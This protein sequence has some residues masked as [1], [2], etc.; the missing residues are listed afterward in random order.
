M[1]RQE[2]QLRQDIE[3]LYGF[4]KPLLV[5]ILIMFK[6]YFTF[7]FGESFFRDKTVIELIIEN[8]RDI[9]QLE[10]VKQD[11]EDAQEL[12]KRYKEEIQELR[13]KQIKSLGLIS[14]SNKMQRI[15]ELA[16]HVAPT[17]SAILI[18]G[19]SGTGKGVLTKY[20]HKVS[21]RSEGPFITINCA[22]IPESLLESELFGYESGAFTGARQKGKLGLIELAKE[23][24]LFLDEIAEVPLH[25]QSKLLDVIQNHR[26][27]RVGGQEVINVDVRIIVATNRN[28]KEMV[29][30]DLRKSLLNYMAA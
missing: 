2:K 10:I 26:F 17:D 6:N 4:D 19:E 20:I 18:Y 28:I 7:N 16:Q 11:L 21:N 8:A 9:T 22:A 13:K 29:K 30:K 3:R 25:L 24:T 23:G 14:H 1:G 12:V 27:I 15:L 5:R